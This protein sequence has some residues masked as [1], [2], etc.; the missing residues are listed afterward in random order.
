MGLL[1]VAGFVVIAAEIARRMSTPN[2]GKSPASTA[3]SQR[4]PLPAGAQVV[5]MT[6]VND[7]LVV[8]VET[9]G[10]PAFAYIVDTKSGVLLGTVEFPPGAPRA[11]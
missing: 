1:I 3:F 10:G 5:S 8:H 11:P 4:I 9:K 7:R 6:N 2:A